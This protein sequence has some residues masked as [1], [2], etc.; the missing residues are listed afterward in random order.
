MFDTKA[1]AAAAQSAMPAGELLADGVPVAVPVPDGVPVD[2]GVPVGVPVIDGV[3]LL[4][5]VLDAVNGAAEG[6]GSASLD[7]VSGAVVP[8]N[9]ARRSTRATG[10]TI[11]TPPTSK[12][13]IMFTARD[14]LDLFIARFSIG[15]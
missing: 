2:D 10:D 3:A 13:A 7:R 4:E 11:K 15:E 1:A 12:P 9:E 14:I 8:K 5:G 6:D